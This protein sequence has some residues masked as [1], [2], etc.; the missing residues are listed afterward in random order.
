MHTGKNKPKNINAVKH[1]IYRTVDSIMD[2]YKV[3][4]DTAYELLG[5]FIDSLDMWNA[6]ITHICKSLE[7]NYLFVEKLKTKNN[8]KKD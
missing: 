5:H 7:K 8:I 4:R 3:D 1:P 6:F 2:I